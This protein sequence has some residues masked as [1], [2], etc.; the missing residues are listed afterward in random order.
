MPRHRGGTLMIIPRDRRRPGPMQHGQA[1]ARPRGG[2]TGRRITN[3]VAARQGRAASTSCPEPRIAWDC[4]SNPVAGSKN[5]TRLPR[6]H[7]LQRN[8]H[9]SPYAYWNRGT[10]SGTGRNMVQGTDI[11]DELAKWNAGTVERMVL[12]ARAGAH[13]VPFHGSIVPEGYID[14]GFQSLSQSGQAVPPR[15]H[16]SINIRGGKNGRQV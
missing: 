16:G 1:S 8:L 12:Y 7:L 15:F 10:G 9:G 3:N 5:A 14:R 6:P 4:P 2:A 13:V 11:A